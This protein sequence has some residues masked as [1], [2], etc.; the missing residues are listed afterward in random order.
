MNATATQSGDVSTVHVS[1]SDV[2]TSDVS[3]VEVLDAE[4]MG[5]YLRARDLL[6]RG[7]AAASACILSL[8]ERLTA[9][10]AALSERRRGDERS[11]GALATATAVAT[12]K[13]QVWSVLWAL[14]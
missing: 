5:S 13:W 10:L 2:S 11:A 3:T 7:D 8:T 9:K 1:T 12:A 4:A 6:A 14:F